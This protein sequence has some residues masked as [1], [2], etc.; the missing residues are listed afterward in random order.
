M[1]S[2]SHSCPGRNSYAWRFA[3]GTQL[4]E[5]GQNVLFR[6]SSGCNM[7]CINRGYP[8]ISA[9]RDA[10][11]GEVVQI[12]P[13][14]LGKEGMV[15]L[16]A[17]EL[18][19]V[20]KLAKK[21]KRRV[22]E[23]G[24]P[25]RYGFLPAKGVSRKGAAAPERVLSYWLMGRF[26][27]GNMCPFLSTPAENLRTEDGALKCL[28]YQERPLQCRAYPVHSMYVDT[29]TEEKVAQ[30]DVGCRWVAERA[31]KGEWMVAQAF[32]IDSMRNLDYGS[33]A[34]LH[35]ET[36]D[37]SRTT[38]WAHPTGVFGK[39]QKPEHVIDSWVEVIQG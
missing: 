13:Q 7:C 30:L 29:V 19:K 10:K 25:I 35:S 18:P 26:D 12:S 14:S 9:V 6:C 8:G 39:G 22:D 38:F 23:A 1:E 33:F 11:S 4:A 31:L 34:R 21:L 36:F 20:M 17:W 2:E 15:E 5:A 16:Q 27:D 28:I 37:P 24:R 32:P 3:S